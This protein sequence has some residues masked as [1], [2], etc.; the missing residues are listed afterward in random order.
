MREAGSFVYRASFADGM[1]EYEFDHVFIGEYDGPFSPDP[2]EVAEMRY[3]PLAELKQDMLDHPGRY[4]VWF[5]TAL[6][7][8][9]TGREKF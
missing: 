6:G 5:F 1:T 2:E 9:E 7:I 3:V 4:A 8:A